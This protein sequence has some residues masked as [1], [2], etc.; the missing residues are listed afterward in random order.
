MS[1]NKLQCS[2]D[3]INQKNKIT[4]N[5]EQESRL[6]I[7]QDCS[8]SGIAFYTYQLFRDEQLSELRITMFTSRS[9]IMWCSARNNDLLCNL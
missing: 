3:G 9:L 2:N 5:T 7:Y 6:P 8:T 4:G 1:D